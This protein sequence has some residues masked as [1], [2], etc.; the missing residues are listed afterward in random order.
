MA[1][2]HQ[3]VA[4][5]LTITH[6]GVHINYDEEVLALV[7]QSGLRSYKKRFA[8]FVVSVAHTYNHPRVLFLFL[9]HAFIP[10]GC[11]SVPVWHRVCRS[12]RRRG[13]PAESSLTDLSLIE[14]KVEEVVVVKGRRVT[15]EDLQIHPISVSLL[16]ILLSFP[17][18]V[19]SI[20]HRLMTR[21]HLLSFTTT[22]ILTHQLSWQESLLLLLLVLM[23][24]SVNVTERPHSNLFAV[25][26]SFFL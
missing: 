21:L 10:S 11:V 23:F 12:V 20:P 1:E 26:L 16:H 9:L 17:F 14:R 3:A 24:L 19:I 18:V 25:L 7:F 22:T 2:A 15:R 13:I 6:E 4:F 5:N 8:R